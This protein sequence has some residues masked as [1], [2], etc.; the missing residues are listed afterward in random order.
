[1]CNVRSKWRLDDSRGD[2]RAAKE[3][4][5]RV[6]ENIPKIKLNLKTSQHYFGSYTAVCEMRGEKDNTHKYF[7][8]KFLFGCGCELDWL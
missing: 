2:E 6:F 8:L 7:R 5:I 3:N 4:W 1:M